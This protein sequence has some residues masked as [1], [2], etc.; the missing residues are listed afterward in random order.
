M[1]I[2][3]LAVPAL[4]GVILMLSAASPQA[5]EPQTRHSD[6]DGEILPVLYVADVQA[7]VGFYTDVLGF[8]F[9]HYFDHV[10]GGSVTEWPHEAP[11][12]YAEMWSGPT[13]FALH[14]GDDEYEQRIG[15]SIHYFGVKEVEAHHR[16]VYERLGK[17]SDIID[18][19]WMKMFSVIDPDGHKLFFQTRPPED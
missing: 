15:G 10:D 4:A 14:L 2:R 12:L 13:R 18:R 3:H 9:D 6:F 19:P 16:A 5:T 1:R 17:P 11:P 8:R 7:S